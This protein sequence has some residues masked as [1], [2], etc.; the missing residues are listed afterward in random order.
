[1]VLKRSFSKLDWQ[2]TPE[3]V[4]HY[5]MA[6]ERT[7][8]DMQQRVEAPEKRIKK[9]EGKKKGGTPQTIDKKKIATYWISSKMNPPSLRDSK[10]RPWRIK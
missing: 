4:R 7:L 2:L 3:P 9:F 10:L 8:H 6:S 5:I 1:M